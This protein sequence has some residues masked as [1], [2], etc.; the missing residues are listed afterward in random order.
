VAERI[1]MIDG[2]PLHTL[3][4]MLGATRLT[5]D[6]SIPAAQAM[7]D[8][9]IADLEAMHANA[10]ETLAAAESADDR[11]TANLLDDLRD[12]MEKDL[13]MLNAWKREAE[14]AWS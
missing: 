6:E 3:S 10:G 2:V 11:G 4:S 12:G 7:V 1:L 8:G 5:E 13:W 9:I 14:K